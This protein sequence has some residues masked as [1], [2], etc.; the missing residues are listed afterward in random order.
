[1]IKMKAI[2]FY[3]F[4]QSKLQY[5]ANSLIILKTCM[6]KLLYCLVPQVLVPWLSSGKRKSW[7]NICIN[8]YYR[9]RKYYG[10]Y[11]QDMGK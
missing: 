6:F 1:M 9:L 4:W 10:C 7:F 3:K 2:F 8:L 11:R 5:L